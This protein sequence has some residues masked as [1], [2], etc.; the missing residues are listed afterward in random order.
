MVMPGDDPQALLAPARLWDL[1][2][3]WIRPHQ[4][5]LV[6]SALYT[7]HSLIASRWRAGPLLLAGDSAHQTPPFLGQGMCAGIRDASN[8][9]WKLAAKLHGWGSEALLDSILSGIH[10]AGVNISQLSKTEKICCVSGIAELIGSGL[11]NRQSSCTRCW[12]GN[13]PCV[14]LLRIK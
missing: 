10:D 13:L 7:F 2:A 4:A 8:L 14:N 12:I 11:I 9:A 1:L 5:R 3:P 6:R